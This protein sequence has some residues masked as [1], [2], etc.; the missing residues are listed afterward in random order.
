LDKSKVSFRGESTVYQRT[1]DEGGVIS[2][3]F[4]PQCGSTVFYEAPWMPGSVAVPIGAFSNPDLPAPI[5]QI[6]GNRKH[7]W[8]ELPETTI[9]YFE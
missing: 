7:H 1:G 6:Y 3:H 4:C 8:V 9:E 2:F 5:M